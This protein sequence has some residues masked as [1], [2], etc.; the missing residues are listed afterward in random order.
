[1]FPIFLSSNYFLKLLRDLRQRR[2]G[3]LCGLKPRFPNLAGH[4]N[5]LERVLYFKNC[6]CWV[7]CPPQESASVALEWSPKICIFKMLPR[8]LWRSAKFGSHQFKEQLEISTPTS[9]E[10]LHFTE[11]QGLK[12]ASTAADTFLVKESHPLKGSGL[13]VFQTHL[14]LCMNYTT[15]LESESWK[16]TSERTLLFSTRDHH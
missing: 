5:H 7:P 3:L 4:Q 8:Q 6:H 9:Y 15:S 2:Q 12:L 16:S 10:I 11:S 13:R 14:Y 1:M